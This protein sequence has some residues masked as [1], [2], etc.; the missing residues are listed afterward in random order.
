M[1]ILISVISLVLQLLNPPLSYSQPD[2]LW[3]KKFGGDGWDKAE[4][5]KQTNDGGFIIVGNSSSFGGGW[6]I[7]TDSLGVEIW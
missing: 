7:R 5:I 6:L 3:T 2:T 1:L 4:S